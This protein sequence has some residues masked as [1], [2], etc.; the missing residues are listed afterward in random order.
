MAESKF[1]V[2][3]FEKGTVG[4]EPAGIEPAK[5]NL[6]EARAAPVAGSMPRRGATAGAITPAGPVAAVVGAPHVIQAAL[7]GG[8]K[9]LISVCPTTFWLPRT[10]LRNA[11]R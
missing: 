1:S 10:R 6:G 8:R 7:L 2:A 9:L 3:G 4:F 5:L 11:V